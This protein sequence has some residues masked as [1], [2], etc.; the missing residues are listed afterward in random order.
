MQFY[1]SV[2]IWVRSWRGGDGSTAGRREAYVAFGGPSGGDG[3]DGGSIYLQAN[4]NEYTL[5]PYKVNTIYKAGNGEHGKWKDL[6]GRSGEDKVLIVP[7]WTHLMDT[8]TWE[9]IATLEFH[10]QQ[11]KIVQ[12]GRGGLGNKHFVNAQKQWSTIGLL[13][14]PARQREITLELQ[15]LADVG[16]VW[17][18]SVGK[19]S[20][21]NAVSNVKAK[22]AEYHFTTLVPNLWVISHRDRSFTMIDI[23]GLITGAGDWKWLG[24]DF[25]R[26]VQKSS[27]LALTMDVSRY[28]AG[29]TDSLQLLTERKK[30]LDATYG[31]WVHTWEFVW[32]ELLNTFTSSDEIMITKKRCLVCSKIDLLF[33]ES[34]REEYKQEVYKQLTEYLWIALSPEQFNTIYFM[35]SSATREWVDWFL[36]YCLFHLN[37]TATADHDEMLLLVEEDQEIVCELLWDEIKDYL[38]EE[39]Y[40]EEKEMKKVNIRDVRHPEVTF[41]TFTLPWWNDEA[42][43]WYRHR[44]EELRILPWLRKQW[45]KKWDIMQVA[46][47]YEWYDERWIKW[48]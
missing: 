32:D 22:V 23:P 46:S 36:D 40:L 1:D 14:E 24:N 47:N 33:D 6:Y 34:L 21:I 13:W 39:D 25:L 41:M 2:T 30:Y 20:L 11:I 43:I 5:M 8:K 28:E 26:H 31:E 38:K 27:L 3:W 17:S 29:I 15:L 9:K 18:P 42:E 16:L 7:V 10:G 37:P 12:W 19:S 45:L 4:H 44:L 48:E 35:A